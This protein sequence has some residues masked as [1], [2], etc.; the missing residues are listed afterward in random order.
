MPERDWNRWKE[1]LHRGELPGDMF[2]ET[3]RWVWWELQIRYLV[4]TRADS[5][6]DIIEALRRGDLIEALLQKDVIEDLLQ[7]V[8]KTVLARGPKCPDP[9]G[10]KAWVGQIADEVITKY[11]ESRE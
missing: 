2:C 8:Y 3:W 4:R 1:Q 5:A 6:D 7:E 11:L 10:I 9:S